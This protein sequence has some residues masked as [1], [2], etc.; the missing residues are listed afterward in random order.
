MKS[1]RQADLFLWR[2]GFSAIVLIGAAGLTSGAL[3]EDDV[4]D[5]D[6]VTIIDGVAVTG[7]N[8]LLG[9]PLWDLGP[10]FGLG[11]FTFV[12]GHNDEG[13]IPRELTPDTPPATIL[14]TTVDENNLARLGLTPSDIDP[15]LINVPL[16]EVAVVVD[17]AGN[18][19]QVPLVTEVP[20]TDVSRA[21]PSGP[22]TL[23]AWLQARGRAVIRCREDGTSSIR[24]T[25]GRLVKSGIYTVWGVFAVEGEGLV[26]APLGGVPNLVNVGKRGFGW[27]ERSL[28]FCPTNPRPGEGVLM[29][30]DVDYHSDASVY[31]GVPD[32]PLA[33]LPGGTVT[34]S[35]VAFPVNASPL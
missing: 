23:G 21:L 19:S 17:P 10:P 5:D 20:G 16:H 15:A 32:L 9:N 11:G 34:H 31:G 14:A 13:G 29:F 27:F 1:L 33:G 6:Y 24:L 26:P 35:H 22:I 25:F 2:L 18:R 30:I 4:Y 7:A 28:N 3:A 8:R 12:A